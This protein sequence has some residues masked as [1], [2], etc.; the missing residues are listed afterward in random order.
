MLKS[1]LNKNEHRYS[2]LNKG[3]VSGKVIGFGS[4]PGTDFKCFE[5]STITANDSLES[6]HVA[7]E[8]N[9]HFHDAL[10]EEKLKQGIDFP[11]EIVGLKGENIYLPS[12]DSEFDVVISVHVLC[13]ADVLDLVLNNAGITLNPGGKF[14]FFEHVTKD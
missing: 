2:M 12:T 1:A 11:M 3:N 5:N 14:I 13:S 7:S 6:E 4:D 10:K 9:E 8:P